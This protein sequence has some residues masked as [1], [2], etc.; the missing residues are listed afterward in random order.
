MAPG[1]T[2]RVSLRLER[3]AFS[4]YDP[5]H[6]DWNM[7]PGEFRI[8]VGSSSRGI[9]LDTGIVFSSASASSISGPNAS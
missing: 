4:F 1:E 5:A 3:D 2:V 8:M 9:R 6:R 7:E